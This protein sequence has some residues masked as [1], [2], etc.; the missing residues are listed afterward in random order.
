MTFTVSSREREPPPAFLLRGLTNVKVGVD[1][2]LD[3][4]L[5]LD[6]EA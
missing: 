3:K 6:V 2:L 4:R 1:G 5:L